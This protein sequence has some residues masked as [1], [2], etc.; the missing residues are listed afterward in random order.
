MYDVYH[1]GDRDFACELRNSAVLLPPNSPSFVF[2]DVLGKRSRLVE[3]QIYQPFK[4]DDDGKPKTKFK[5]SPLFY[6]F[7]LGELALKRDEP[8]L[9]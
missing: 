9:T 1:Y 5:L 3:K 4:S 8:I 6:T 2:R 7:I